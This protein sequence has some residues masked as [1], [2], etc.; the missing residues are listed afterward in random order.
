MLTTAI[1]V[2]IL[3]SIYMF[4]HKIVYKR[5]MQK[6]LGRK[7]EDRELTSI[8]SWMQASDQVRDEER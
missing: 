4:I 8:S 2:F 7:V 3:V 5:V 1:I 6:R